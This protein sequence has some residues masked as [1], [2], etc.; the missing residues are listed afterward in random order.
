MVP[1][2]FYR[3][4][5]PKAMVRKF[6]V[7]RPGRI[8]YS[9]NL[10]VFFSFLIMHAQIGRC[11]FFHA[12]PLLLQSCLWFLRDSPTKLIQKRK[13]KSHPPASKV[14][15]VL[16]E[17]QWIYLP[18]AKWKQTSYSHQMES[19]DILLVWSNISYLLQG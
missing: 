3:T 12:W 10:N 5:T 11:G 6:I 14:W 13:K 2:L 16:P 17:K 4:F 15:K 1:T 7:F 18:W 19:F 8:S 9:R